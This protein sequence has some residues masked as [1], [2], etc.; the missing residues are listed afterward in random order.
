MQVTGGKVSEIKYDEFK[1]K[2]RQ[3]YAPKQL[4]Y[5]LYSE[6]YSTKQKADEATEEF[7][8]RKR[9]LFSLLPAPKYS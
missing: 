5:L 4:T 6:I 8:V 2:I 9:M 7:V 3:K 1:D